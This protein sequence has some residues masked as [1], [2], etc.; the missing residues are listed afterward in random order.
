MFEAIILGILQGLTE[1]LPISSSAHLII[2]PWFLGWQGA[3]N[4]LSFSVALHIGTLIALLTYFRDDWI[5]LVKTAFRKDRMIWYIF[6]GTIPAGVIGIFFHERIEHIR[7][8][9][10]IVFT[11]CLVAVLMIIVERRYKDS[12]HLGINK[13]TLKDALIIGIVQA[14]A[15]VP[16]ISRSGI[17]IVTGLMLGFQREASA[18]FSFLLS[19]PLIAGAGIL[20]AKRLFNSEN[21]EFNIFI[22]GVLTSA[23]TGYV[24]IKY[25]L[26]FL[27]NH[28]LMP[29]AYYRFFLAFVIIVNILR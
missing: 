22:T 17:T 2:L 6:L 15:L 27:Q 19:T 11:L 5:M 25:L 7:N 14:L 20:E 9:L 10:L 24:V 28:S 3:V 23:L 12:P 13:I 26:R 4:T 29:F 21:I 18:R 16:G 8:P 1:F